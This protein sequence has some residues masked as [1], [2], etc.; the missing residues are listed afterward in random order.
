MRKF[1]FTL[2]LAAIF[3]SCV[4]ERLVAP[5]VDP[6][7]VAYVSIGIESRRA[8]TR[9]STEDPGANEN[10]LKTLCLVTFDTEGGLVATPD[11]NFYSP[12]DVAGLSPAEA[13]TP[14]PVKVSSAAKY[15]M[16]VANPGPKLLDRL[17]SLTAT[18]TFTS[19]NAAIGGADASEVASGGAF[20][21]ISTG[22]DPLYPWVRIG[23]RLQTVGGAVDETAARANA[24]T[25]R[26][27]VKLERLAAKL[28]VRANG[29]RIS[30]PGNAR[31][32]LSR[33]TVDGVNSAF[34]PFAEKTPLTVAH[35]GSEYA[36]NFYTR[37][38]NF[39]NGHEDLRHIA[40]GS[41]SAPVL[42][43]PGQ[44]WRREGGA[45]LE[46]V[47]ENTVAADE[48]VYANVTRI[49]MEAVYTPY[50]GRMWEE[51]ADWFL[52]DNTAYPNLQLLQQSYQ[53]SNATTDFKDACDRFYARVKAANPAIAGRGFYSLTSADL[54]TIKNGGQAVKEADKPVI[55]WYQ[56][57]KCYYSYEIRH[58]DETTEKM[59][60][61]KYGV[62][63]NNWY[64]LTLNSVKGP[65]TPWL[66]EVDDPGP[67]DPEPNDPVDPADSYLG[68]SVNV[69]P[70][71]SWQTGMEEID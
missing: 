43:V 2:A 67:G 13:R 49:V 55:R 42:A 21:M 53:A 32:T 70:W 40:V 48:Q 4:R 3:A 59:A 37:D 11:G 51:G 36:R 44:S 9:G 47:L 20:T 60:F 66:P 10:L 68:V 1:L 6:S 12:I 28:N 14:D 22:D 16:V 71:V 45:E 23:D 63:R 62:V 57:G 61:G 39:V 24:K 30:A 35:T 54:N 31:V 29:V 50:T 26:L 69:D 65:G 56:K 34:Y 64:D 7:G 17:R 52:W 25:R 15:L 18:S 33:W 58:D 5:A 46:Y 19:F 27:A 8:A 41:D 38:P